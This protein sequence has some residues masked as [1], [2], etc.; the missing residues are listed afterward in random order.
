MRAAKARHVSLT[1]AVRE[2]LERL[3]ADI[4]REKAA[5]DQAID[6]LLRE[7]DANPSE[8]VYGDAEMYDEDGLPR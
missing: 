4:D 7:F 2:A 5:R 6:D 8:R 3:V 1:E